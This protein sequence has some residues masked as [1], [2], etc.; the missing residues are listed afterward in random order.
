MS[1][2]E[3]RERG[4]VSESALQWKAF[5]SELGDAG[6][7]LHERADAARTEQQRGQV[8]EALLSTLV[9][10][11]VAVPHLDR[12]HPEW[13]PLINSSMRKF[14]PCP[15]T[16]YSLAYI[17][18]AGAYRMAGRRGSVLMVHLQ[19]HDGDP[20]F[21]E[22]TKLLAD[23]NLDDCRIAPDGSFEIIFS[24]E[25]PVGYEGDWVA[26]DPSKDELFLLARQISYDWLTEID[27]QLTIQRIDRDICKTHASAGE[28]ERQMR[29]LP[30]YLKGTITALMNVMD[31]QHGRNCPINEVQDVTSTLPTITDQAYTHGVLK[32]GDNDAW[33]AECE[34]PQGAPY[35]SV[36]LMDY[37]YNTLD[38]TYRQSGLNGF[39]AAI[40][41]DGKVRIVVCERDPG[42]ANW[43]DKSDYDRLQI[44]FRWFGSTHPALTTKVVAFDDLMQ[45]LPAGVAMVTPEQRQEALR[46]RA[47]GVQL[48]RRW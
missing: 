16:V 31:V 44:R 47:M 36:Q 48:R 3:A 30:A 7:E 5:A 12:D 32:L 17:R 34:I 10:G 20:G 29:R 26:L 37:F 22:P 2:S 15:D 35:W 25:R 18:G 27:A 6:L 33:I 41:A 23:I 24:P 43:L 45:H 42:V 11:L 40:D 14:N 46:K 8:N 28:F 21:R 4:A 19:L 1:G 39:Q 38:F 9:A 13:V